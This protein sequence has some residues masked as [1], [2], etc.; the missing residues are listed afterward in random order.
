VTIIKPDGTTEVQRQT[1]G[2]VER[3]VAMGEHGKK[4]QRCEELRPPAEFR[5]RA[6]VLR[7]WCRDCRREWAMARGRL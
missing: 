5:D 3:T 4:C 6:G 7:P 2:E 1:A